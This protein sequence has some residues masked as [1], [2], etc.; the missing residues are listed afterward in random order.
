MSTAELPDRIPS[1]PS[2]LIGHRPAKNLSNDGTDVMDT[3]GYGAGRSM[4]NAHVH[5]TAPAS[6]KAHRL[7]FVPV[8]PPAHPPTRSAS[9]RAE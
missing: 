7:P 8:R 1:F 4:Q 9:C 5:M 6:G 2:F 3:S